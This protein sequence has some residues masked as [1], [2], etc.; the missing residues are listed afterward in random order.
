MSLFIITANF[1][2]DN[3]LQEIKNNYEIQNR[4]IRQIIT[5]TVVLKKSSFFPREPLEF[6]LYPG[7]KKSINSK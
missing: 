2:Q 6:Y 4:N 1:L 3:N 7:T 5:P